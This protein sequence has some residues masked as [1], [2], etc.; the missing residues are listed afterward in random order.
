[1]IPQWSGVVLAITTFVTIGAGHVLVRRLHSK[2]GT[3][4]GIP[5]M[6]TGGVL[7]FVS[8]FLTDNL[9][10][11]LVGIV[12]ITTFWDGIEFFRQEKRVK[13]GHV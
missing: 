4:L 10:S 6:L 2:F 11:G 1:M 13:R 8:L 3:R 5:F 9:L 7:M 12:S